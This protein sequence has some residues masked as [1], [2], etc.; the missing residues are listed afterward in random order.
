[1]T[2]TASAKRPWVAIVLS[3]V[4]PG[5]GHVYLREWLRTGLWLVL[6]FATAWLV[7]PPDLIP[8]ETSYEA[9][10]QASRNLPR[11]ASFLILGLRVLNVID[12]YVL[13]RQTTRTDPVESGRQC[14]ECG[15][16]L[17]E[18]DDDLTFCPWCATEL[19]SVEEAEADSRFKL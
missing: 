1:M 6:L 13:A 4:F 17:S 7:I 5:L 10:M 15:H 8:Q 3:V 18:A 11:D 14:P 9:I 12:A 19:E 2:E 16:D